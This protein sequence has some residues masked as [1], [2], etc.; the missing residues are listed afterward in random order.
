MESVKLAIVVAKAENGVIGKDNAL[1]WHLP[2]DLKYFKRV[3]MGRPIVMGRLTFESIGRPLPGRANIV[4]TRQTDWQA[5]GVQVAHSLEQAVVL[6]EK[7][8]RP[9]EWV[10]II[11]GANL[12]EQ[13][14]PSCNRLYLTQVHAEV[15]GDAFFPSLVDSE[16]KE[17]DRESH[18]SD[19]KN[20]YDYSFLTLDR[21]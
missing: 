1:P 6:A 20:P 11:G 18:Q 16:W 7:S 12:Y 19:E 8:E 9:D 10:M 2:E 5:D 4:I 21:I 13:A 14:L 15:D 17:T 3:T